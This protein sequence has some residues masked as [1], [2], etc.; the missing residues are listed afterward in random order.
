MYIETKVKYDKLQE[1]GVSAKKT[2]ESFLVDAL[3]FAEA[4]ARIIKERTP[5]ISG[6]FTVNAVKKTKI[7]EIFFNEAGGKF[8][9]V[10][11]QITTIDE[12]PEELGKAPVERK[13]TVLTLAQAESIEE[14]LSLFKARMK[15]TLA[16]YE[17]VA[18]SETQI[19]EIYSD[20]QC[21]HE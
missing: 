19:L 17:V 7:G 14:S 6:D 12:R 18:V 9:L 16:D 2:T 20:K 5:Y 11:W 1:S 13:T 21:G 8:Y 3:S 15:G 10:K 4:E